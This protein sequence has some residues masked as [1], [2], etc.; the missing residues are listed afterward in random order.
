MAKSM[1][2]VEKIDHEL[3][4][5]AEDDKLLTP[6]INGR[7]IIRDRTPKKREIETIDVDTTPPKA[8][9]RVYTN[10][11][12]PSYARS[13]L[14]PQMDRQYS[15]TVTPSAATPLAASLQTNNQIS[16]IWEEKICNLCLQKIDKLEGQ[17][18]EKYLNLFSVMSSKQPKAQYMVAV[19]VF[20][21][22]KYDGVEKVVE[23]MIRFFGQ[24]S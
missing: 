3:S 5:D 19:N 12:D 6:I 4:D 17:E 7:D 1:M 11:L 21:F 2:H 15:S 18:A 20:K 9:R 10:G 13:A 23:T 22:K 8:M 16:S 14:F 24:G